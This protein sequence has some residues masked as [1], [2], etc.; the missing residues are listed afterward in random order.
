MSAA[1]KGAQLEAWDV[2]LGVLL[3]VELAALPGAGGED[4]AAGGGEARMVIA[5]EEL[6]AAEAALLE[7]HEKVAPV[8]FGLA[9]GDAGAKDLAQA[10]G[11]DAQGDEH[12]AVDDA[13]AVADLFISGIEDDVGEGGEGPGA[14]AFEFGIEARSAV[15]DVGGGDGGAAKFFE[16]GGDFAGG[17]ALDV[18]LCE[19]ELESLL[20]ADAFFESGGIE[21]EIAA[22]LRD[23]QG[24][25]AE[26]GREGLWFE[27]IGVAGAS[28]GALEGL[29]LEH[30]G[31]LRAHGLVDEDAEA[32]GEGLGA[33]VGKKLKDGFEEFRM[34]VAGHVRCGVGCVEAP[35]PEPM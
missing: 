10:V 16:D 22:D 1:P 11:A 3:E 14:P 2:G 7:A 6:E 34:I 19:G 9:E 21:V 15:A 5:D 8:D 13:T 30:G 33:L 23:G 12:G 27:A 25:G 20:A 18:H 32:R 28:L 31:A 29:G 17:D 4:G 26:A 35:R 24:D